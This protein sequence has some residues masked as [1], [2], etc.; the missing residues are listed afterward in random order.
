MNADNV[1]LTLALELA[2]LKNCDSTTGIKYNPKTL[3]FWLVFYRTCHTAGLNL[4]SGSKHH[5]HV[6]GNKSDKGHFDPSTGSFN[7]AVPDVKTL[8]HQKKIDRFLMAGILHSSFNIIDNVKQFI[9]EYDAKRIASGLSSDGYG[10][11]NL[12]R[13]ENP[14]LQEAQKQLEEELNLIDKLQEINTAYDETL[15]H[16]LIDLLHNT[17]FRIQRKWYS[18]LSHKKYLRLRKNVWI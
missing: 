5:G 7:F 16:T 4:V 12:W 17:S 8:H 13:Y 2:K 10:D 1:P 3:D 6:V 14:N 9:L 11:V 18:F 15:L